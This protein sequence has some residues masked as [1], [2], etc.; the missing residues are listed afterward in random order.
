[1]VDAKYARAVRSRLGRAPKPTEEA[2]SLVS[3]APVIDLHVHTFNARYLPLEGILLGKRDVSLLATFLT[4]PWAKSIAAAAVA[5]VELSDISSP[6]K[7][8]AHAVSVTQACMEAFDGDM[9]AVNDALSMQCVQALG[10]AGQQ[11]QS[12]AAAIEGRS[13]L[14]EHDKALARI[15]AVE[16]SLRDNLTDDDWAQL[17]KALG[18]ISRALNRSAVDFLVALRTRDGDQE[19]RFHRAFEGQVDLVVSH[20]MD[21]API[22]DQEE[23]GEVLIEFP[24][25]QLDRMNAFQ[26]EPDSKML[27]FVAYNPFRGGGSLDIVKEAIESRGAY[28][29][30]V[31]PP[32]GYRP[33]GNSIPNKPF[34]PLTGAPERQ[35]KRRYI[36]PAS[37]PGKQTRLTGEELDAR[38]C[39]LFG[40]CAE[41]DIPV[42]THCH[43][44]EFE[45]RA[46]YGVCMA[47][48]RW[49]RPILEKFP[50][51]RV[52]FGHAGGED[53][54]FGSNRLTAADGGDPQVERYSSWGRMVFELCVT[55]ENVYCEFGA[56]DEPL[57]PRG[58]DRFTAL[59]SELIQHPPIGATYDFASKVCYGSDWFMPSAATD[60]RDA[61]ASWRTIFAS[62]P[63]LPFHR[64]F[65]AGN[66]WGYLNASMR[67]GDARLPDSVR[68]SLAQFD[69]STSASM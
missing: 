9:D 6:G 27:Y 30:K 66:A 14:E 59:L 35:W 67:R 57:T 58:R 40:Y 52:C 32:A 68:S 25:E 20:T 1:M 50:R 36:E 33:S 48:P 26:S 3:S 19:T 5:E 18:L 54:W 8:E 17:R 44:G 22:Y 38:L 56:L 13:D 4:D 63:L 65:F 45:A 12:E 21:L 51:L 7:A 47:N 61:L 62:A 16:R 2:L 15:D 39:A 23:D 60:R 46:G 10:R 11:A 29:V 64:A 37:A 28:G 53:F 69:E 41:N 34:A 49:W 31:Y 55:Y 42:F 24:T 43:T